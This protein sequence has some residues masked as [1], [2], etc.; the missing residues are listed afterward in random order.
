MKK[1][2]SWRY[3]PGKQFVSFN[4]PCWSVESRDYW[5]YSSAR[6]ADFNGDG[7]LD[8]FVAGG[9]GFRWR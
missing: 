8:L 5:V 4:E 9:G 7:L 2:P 1:S 3:Q 6:L